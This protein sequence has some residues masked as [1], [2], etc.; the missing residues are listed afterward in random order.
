ML[1]EKYKAELQA[2]PKMLARHH[3]RIAFKYYRNKDAQ[4]A[5]MHFKAA[6]AAFPGR[7]LTF[8]Y[9]FS[10]FFGP[11]GLRLILKLQRIS[12]NTWKNPIKKLHCLLI[13]SSLQQ[14]MPISKLRFST[15]KTYT[16]DGYGGKDV[17]TWPVYRFF[18]AYLN[19]DH[20]GARA[21]FCSWYL[22]ELNKYHA[23]P[24]KEGG[25]HGGSLYKLIVEQYIE[26]GIAYRGDIFTDP[27]VVNKAIRKRVDQRLALL[28]SIQQKGYDVTSDNPVKGVKK[29][30]YVYITNGHHRWA[31][32]KALGYHN[33]PKILVI[34]P[35]LPSW[36]NS[37][38][39]IE[40]MIV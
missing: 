8:F 12:A 19:G 16:A 11:S 17:T 26:K 39:N 29:N 25:M 15:Q 35:I 31:A 18:L 34:S 40:N 33:I 28:T 5:R 7:P 20:E 27:E 2:R 10:A 24:K 21:A 9:F 23:I 37:K 36:G 22:A 1:I 14:D 13:D 38:Q 4:S 32:L 30:G 6:F 3:E